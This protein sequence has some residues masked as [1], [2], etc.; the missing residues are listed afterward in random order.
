MLLLWSWQYWLN[1]L[2]VKA[3]SFLLI[4]STLGTINALIIVRMSIF[5]HAPFLYVL[6]WHKPKKK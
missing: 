5:V 1:S 2:M 3:W 4:L 6:V